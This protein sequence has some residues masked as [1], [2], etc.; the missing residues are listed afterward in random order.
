MP[1]IPYIVGGAIGLGVSGWA[2]FTSLAWIDESTEEGGT[3]AA[4]VA[5]TVA[6]LVLMFLGSAFLLM[7]GRK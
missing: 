1:L 3:S 2:A 6:M 7:K 4:V 5:L